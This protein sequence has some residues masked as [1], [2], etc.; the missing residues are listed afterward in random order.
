M[1]RMQF[2][3][4]ALL[5]TCAYGAAV[6]ADHASSLAAM[7]A[8]AVETNVLFQ[9]PGHALAEGRA[10]IVF[11][12][13]WPVMLGLL[14]LADRRARGLAREPGWLVRQLIGHRPETT[15]LLPVVA[16]FGKLL[17]A[18]GNMVIAIYGVSIY[19]PIRAVLSSADVTDWDVQ[20]LVCGLILLLPAFLAGRLVAHWWY[21]GRKVGQIPAI[22]S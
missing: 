2:G 6:V 14:W 17:A 5:Y 21:G 10:V 13:L 22:S 8:G 9:T 7:K 20:S 11:F 16:I 12:L 15:A 1:P 4:T 19:T 18:A 3:P